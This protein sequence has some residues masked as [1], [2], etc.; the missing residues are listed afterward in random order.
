MLFLNHHYGTQ[1]LT[2][3]C[4]ILASTRKV[5]LRTEGLNQRYCRAGVNLLKKVFYELYNINF[6]SH[7]LPNLSYPDI[8]RIKVLDPTSVGLPFLF[9]EEDQYVGCH[10]S[11]FK[12]QLEFELLKAE[13]SPFSR[14]KWDRKRYGLRSNA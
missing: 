4:A 3:L 2:K 1:S 11:G 8:S 12:I 9:K 10:R 7:L 14:T 5:S 13:S 6:L